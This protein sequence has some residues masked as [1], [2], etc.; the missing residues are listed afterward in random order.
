LVAETTKSDTEVDDHGL[1][2]YLGGVVWVA[3]FGC[4]VQFE[5]LVIV[6]LGITQLEHFNTSLYHD[7]LLEHR[8][9][10]GVKFCVDVLE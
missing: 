1:A 2:E 10:H 7:V 6:N 9:D 3:E 4:Q 5:V 8:I